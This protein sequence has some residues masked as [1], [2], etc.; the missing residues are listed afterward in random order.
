MRMICSYMSCWR[1]QAYPFRSI[2]WGI[3][4]QLPVCNKHQDALHQRYHVF[5]VRSLSQD[6]V[7]ELQLM[8]FCM[9][10]ITCSDLRCVT[11]WRFFIGFHSIESQPI[12]TS[13]DHVLKIPSNTLTQTALDLLRIAMFLRNSEFPMITLR[14]V[15]KSTPLAEHHRDERFTK[16]RP[17]RHEGWLGY[18]RIWDSH[19]YTHY[20]DYAQSCWSK[21]ASTWNTSKLCNWYRC[22][23]V[24]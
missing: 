11:G 2:L 21:E 6:A 8:K 20:A 24:V 1:K 22:V 23:C 15:W 5:V 7:N 17:P 9:E 14:Y 18:P 19:D 4:R 10:R 13:L 3:P 12:P 16:K